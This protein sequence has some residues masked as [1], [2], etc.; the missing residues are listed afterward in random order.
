[1]AAAL[2]AMGADVSIGESI[3]ALWERGGGGLRPRVIGAAPLEADVAVFQRVF[4]PDLLPVLRGLKEQGVA[5]V[6]DID[7]D[8]MALGPQHPAFSIIHPS[9]TP[10]GRSWGVLR[11]AI[12]IADVVTVS[13]PALARKYNGKVVRNCIPRAY[14]SMDRSPSVPTP[15]I[16]WPGTPVFHPGDLEVVG[17]AVARVCA[18][19]V[20]HFRAIGDERTLPILSVPDQQ[21]QPAVL[22]ETFAYARVVADLD[23]GIVPLCDTQFN[24]AKSWLKMAEFSSLGVPCVVSPSAENLM[25]HEQ[26]IGL[27]ARRPREWQR[28]L[29]TLA[30]SADLRAEMGGRARDVM[31]DLTI[32]ETMAPA[33]WDAWVLA[34]ERASKGQPVPAGILSAS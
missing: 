24:A 11:E 20:A 28:H 33:V 3:P 25:L 14:L 34:Y 18:T 7:D 27:V 5:V 2:K 26:G 23:I 15:V 4:S 16:G 1:V 29:M 13:T 10:T 21:H 30:G 22:L 9:T 19:G 17:D 12:Q 32:E 31:H 6:I 8:F